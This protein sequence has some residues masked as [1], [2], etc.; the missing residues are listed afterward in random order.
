MRDILPLGVVL[1][2]ADLTQVDL[3]VYI[4]TKV[5]VKT[6]EPKKKLVNFSNTARY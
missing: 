1:Q 4:S 6:F 5:S 2:V 3:E